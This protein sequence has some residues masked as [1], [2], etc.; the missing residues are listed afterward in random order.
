MWHACYIFALV[1][2]WIHEFQPPFRQMSLAHDIASEDCSVQSCNSPNPYMHHAL[3]APV[4]QTEGVRENKM[5]LGSGLEEESRNKKVKAGHD[6]WFQWVQE[7]DLTLKFTTK[8]L[9]SFY[10][11]KKEHLVAFYIMLMYEHFCFF[12]SIRC[13]PVS[14][15]QEWHIT[16]ISSFTAWLERNA[17]LVLRNG[18]DCSNVVDKDSFTIVC[19]TPLQKLT[20]YF[21]QNAANAYTILCSGVQN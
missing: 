12:Y 21:A 18:C 4:W 1:P 11:L 10:H 2:S 17:F 5:M 15:N 19:P 3:N 6:S 13:K 14:L 16:L 9:S 7:I 8:P 20:Y